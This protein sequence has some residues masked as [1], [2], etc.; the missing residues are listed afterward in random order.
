[1]G[2]EGASIHA[3][4]PCSCPTELKREPR[5]WGSQPLLRLKT[6]VPARDREG[7]GE[8]EMGLVNENCLGRG[9]ERVGGR[10]EGGMGT[11]GGKRSLICLFVFLVFKMLTSS[12][13]LNPSD[14]KG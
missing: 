13:F 3:G 2:S 8:G 9:Q 6:A 14:M 11:E 4:G 1:M 12:I 10:E 7:W 5:L